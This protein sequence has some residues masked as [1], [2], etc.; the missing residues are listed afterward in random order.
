MMSSAC[1]QTI[2]DLANSL[3]QR[4]D[5][6]AVLA[7]QDDRCDEWSFAELSDSI[8]RLAGGLRR[9][10][11]DKNTPVLLCAPN[12]PEWIVAYFSAAC[13]GASVVPID[14]QS[15]DEMVA[16]I[17]DET[18]CQFAFATQSTAKCLADLSKAGPMTII[19]ID[20][21]SARAGDGLHWKSL[22]D[23][24][25]ITLPKQSDNDVASILYTSGTTG[26]PKAVPLTHRNFM[27]NL[28]ALTEVSLARPS[29]RVLLPLPLHHAY[30][31]TVGLLASLAVGATLVL[32]SG[33]SGPEIVGALKR[34]QV[35]ILI[36]VPRLYEALIDGITRRLENR[37]HTT[38]RFFRVVLGFSLAVRRAFGLRLGRI[39]FARLHR[40]MAPRLRTVAS[41]GAKLDPNLAWHLEAMGWQVLTGYGLTET[42]PIL[43]YNL[44]HHSRIGSA[45]RPIPGVEVKID[46]PDQEGCGE[47]LV[48]GPNVFCGYRNNPDANDAAFTPSGWFKTGDL[49]SLDRR[50]YLHIVGRAKDILVL[51]GGENVSLESV[52]KHF[53][54]SP[55]IAESAVFEK[56]GKLI[57]L[58]RP[59]YEEIRNYGAARADTL[60]REEVALRNARLPS[61]QRISG[62]RLVHDALP[63]TR[64]GKLKRFL[65]PELMVS[66]VQPS[67]RASDATAAGAAGI[68]SDLE[69]EIFAWLQQRFPETPLS[70]KTSPQL[71]LGID[72][73]DW[74]SLTL[75]LQEHFDVLI[76]EEVLARIVT[77]A[78]LL[79]EAA[80]AVNLDQ[81]VVKNGP[82]AAGV[83]PEDDVWLRPR[84]PI[85]GVLG[86]ILWMM[87]WCVFH[88]LVSIRQSGAKNVPWDRG[89]VLA[90]NHSSYLDAFALAAVLSWGHL[91]RVSW[92]G[93][94]GLLFSG[95]F[96]RLFSRAAGILP[97]DPN[98][99]PAN[100]LALGRAAL[101]KGRVLTWFPEGR[102]SPDG[103]IGTFRE[104]IGQLLEGSQS[105]V[106]P[107]FID[108]TFDAWPAGQR[109]PRL[110]P[111]RV[112]FGVPI[113]VNALRASGSGATDAERITDGLRK[114]LLRLA[115]GTES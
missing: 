19:L 1:L 58:I 97:I 8:L 14:H 36:G 75:E 98:R 108:G 38:Q 41:G 101:Q 76:T 69:K 54:R 52:E 51:P 57:L 27:S 25:P 103:K 2:S 21:P 62:Y 102:R 33:A 80:A 60:V 81:C 24:Q 78:D 63:R 110:A 9:I 93:W 47:I 59:D 107:V 72:S 50:G 90:P 109:W 111:I 87:N 64:L 95:P 55:F 74:T 71:D 23:N 11:V 10:G 86:L 94:T 42:A 31:F 29:D 16:Q 48:R 56:E 61:F 32:P 77:I 46:H 83:S 70:L 115:E 13:L 82:V 28:R 18:D 65:L 34:G 4:G 15:S 26:R 84:G 73:L 96:R 17:V 66:A 67:A 40:Q 104:G 5:D 12:S 99:R 92:A 85:F 39:L 88:T 37:G 7:F 30:A 112:F 49:G 89:V 113:S 106:V 44:R 114:Q 53:D 100:A 6:I 35:T 20:S 3:Q 91:R 105:S 45:G 79:N 68:Q 43:T 22:L